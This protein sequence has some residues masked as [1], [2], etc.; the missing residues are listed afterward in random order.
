MW[1]DANPLRTRPTRARPATAPDG[2]G[3]QR[4][5]GA[6]R[7]GYEGS[8][9]SLS[10]DGED[11][12]QQVR[13]ESGIEATIKETGDGAQQVT[14][15]VS[16]TLLCVDIKHNLVQV[17]LKPQE[18]QIERSELQMED[19]AAARCAVR[20]D[21]QCDWDVG[22]GAEH[23]SCRIGQRSGKGADCDKFSALRGEPVK[24]ERSREFSDAVER[25]DGA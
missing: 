17:D 9:C 13:Q 22:N 12:I 20:A 25:L 16:R 4:S 21:G 1:N 2:H 14:E 7:P 3:A 24:A 8:G 19:V 5:R 18:V 23:G 15:K 6:T 10:E 11:L